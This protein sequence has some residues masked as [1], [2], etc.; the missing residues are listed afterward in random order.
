MFYHLS[1]MI[2]YSLFLNSYNSRPNFPIHVAFPCKQTMHACMPHHQ[3]IILL[4]IFPMHVALPH[5][6]IMQY[7][8]SADYHLTIFNPHNYSCYQPNPHHRSTYL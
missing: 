3:P 2:S 4:P 8:M 7:V 6:Q 5:Q 1:M